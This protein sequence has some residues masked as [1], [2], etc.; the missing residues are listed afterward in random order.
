MCVVLGYFMGST[1][2]NRINSSENG[3]SLR[4]LGMLAE[5]SAE[6]ASACVLPRKNLVA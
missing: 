5:A 2:F 6:V 3:L 4:G 1:T